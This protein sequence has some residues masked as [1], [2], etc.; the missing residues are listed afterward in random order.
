M[1]PQKNMEMDHPIA[2][3]QFA[4]DVLHSLKSLNSNVISIRIGIHTGPVVAGVI[5]KTKFAYDCWGDT[6]NV[7]C[8]FTALTL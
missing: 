6:V 3:I 8:I 4:L 2:V 1:N 7:I 5:G